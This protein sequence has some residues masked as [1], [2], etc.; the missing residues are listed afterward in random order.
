WCAFRGML[1]KSTIYFKGRGG[2]CLFSKAEARLTLG[3][4]PRA[5]AL[6]ALEIG[7]KPFFT[8][9]FPDTSGT[10][11]DHFE[12]WFLTGQQLPVAPTE[13]LDSVIDLGLS[14]AWL[15]PPGSTG[16]A[17]DAGGGAKSP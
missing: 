3:S 11:D 4:S 16:G 9:Y 7:D 6:K 8:A 13:G 15:P 10:L 1:M 2:F 17:A 14:E 5:D 12:S